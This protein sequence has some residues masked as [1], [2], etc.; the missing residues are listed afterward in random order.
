MTTDAA[1]AA[2]AAA[3]GRRIP[4]PA[5]NACVRSAVVIVAVAAL[6]LFHIS[7]E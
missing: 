4:S 5:A 2:A 1:F 3:A 7:S 6:S